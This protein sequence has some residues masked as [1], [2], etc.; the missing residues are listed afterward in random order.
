MGY[1]SILVFYLFVQDLP[2]QGNPVQVNAVV[3]KQKSPESGDFGAVFGGTVHRAD[4]LRT[5]ANRGVSHGD[6]GGVRRWRGVG[7]RTTSCW[8]VKLHY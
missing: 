8:R 5:P 2:V 3:V 4:R 6:R 7:F 1:D